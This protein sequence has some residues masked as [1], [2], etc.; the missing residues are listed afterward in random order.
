[1]N[2]N[3][4]STSTEMAG[5]QNEL[6]RRLSRTADRNAAQRRCQPPVPV[7]LVELVVPPVLVVPVVPVAHF[8]GF[9]VQAIVMHW[10]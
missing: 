8:A 4:E 9:A 1:L 3:D 10:V 7:E 5:A 6:G 2:R